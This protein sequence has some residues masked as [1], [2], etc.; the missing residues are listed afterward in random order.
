M[1]A[2]ALGSA[3]LAGVMS[4]FLLIGRSGMNAAH[5]SV[6]EAEFRRALEEFSQDVRMASAIKWNTASSITL[7]VPDNYTSNGNQVTY[8]YDASTTGPTAQSFYRMPGN[9][10]STA[11][12]T[13]F[14]QCVSV[15]TFRRFNRQN[16]ELTGAIATDAATKRVQIEMNVRRAR[17]TLV[18]ANTSVV[19]AS[20]T[21]RNKVIN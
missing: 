9:A 19:S 10:S 3:I 6:S 2:M 1:V 11:A 5:Y 17:A 15:F 18:A 20:Y 8:A 13:V 14:V 16:L 7:T 12:K 21:L 4:T